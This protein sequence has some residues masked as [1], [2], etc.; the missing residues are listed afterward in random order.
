[1]ADALTR[2]LKAIGS[3]IEIGGD[4]AKKGIEGAADKVKGLFGK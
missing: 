1:M 4:G 3:E 2:E